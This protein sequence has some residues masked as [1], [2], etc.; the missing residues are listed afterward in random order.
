VIDRL[1]G[2]GTAVA[3][4]DG[5]THL[6]FPVAV[7][8]V[9]GEALRD[10][11]IREKATRTVEVGLG[12]GISALFICEGLLMNGRRDTRHV[13]IDPNQ[14]TRFANCGL[15]AIDEA[16]VLELIEHHDEQSEIVLPRL[17]GQAVVR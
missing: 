5:T 2:D 7:A 13:V 4:L 14:S 11:V 8:A 1:V 17:L 3:C 15:Q 10:W 6:L 9:E 12:Y 16:G